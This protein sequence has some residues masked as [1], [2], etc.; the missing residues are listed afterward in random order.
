MPLHVYI[1]LLPLLLRNMTLNVLWC[2]PCTL[3]G[4]LYV[5]GESIMTDHNIDLL[6]AAGRQLYVLL[7]TM[8]PVNC[9]L[10]LA[11]VISDS[12][13]MNQCIWLLDIC[14]IINVTSVFFV[15]ISYESSD[16]YMKCP[17]R[18]HIVCSLYELA[19]Q[20]CQPHSQLQTDQCKLMQLQGIL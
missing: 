15:T 18:D 12:H 11:P 7:L 3:S 16:L 5:G 9:N 17:W 13:F 2:K 8:H 6:S 20:E 4:I 19:L 10:K 14:N 1:A